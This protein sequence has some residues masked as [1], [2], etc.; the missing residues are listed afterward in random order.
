MKAICVTED[1][2][3]EVRDI[4]APT[5]PPEGHVLIDVEA[6]AINHG[7]KTF[8]TS[9]TAAAGLSTSNHDVWGASASGKV[10]AVG[11]DVPEKFA[12]SNV[13]IYR[14]L[15]ASPQIVGL[16]SERAMVPYT[17]CLMLPDNVPVRAY[18]GSLVNVITAYAF[19]EEVAAEG[20]KGVIVTAGNSATGL[21]IA[22]LVQRRDV[23]AIFL[24]RSEVSRTELL[25]SGVRNVLATN[26]E[27][28]GSDFEKLAMQLD[29]TA[30]FDGVGGELITRL[31]PHL[32]ANSVVSFYGFLA[33]SARI[34]LPSS[35]FMAKN[36]V[37][38]RFS[39]FN[40]QT[41]KDKA[42]LSRA[43][44]YLEGIIEDPLF[45]TKL[46]N[47]FTFDQIDAAMAYEP[48]SGAKAIL[49]PSKEVE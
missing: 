20:H 11:R 32:P 37:F 1:R 46:G 24:V 49:V 42:K 22:G 38:R 27:C 47:T 2:R 41:V 40:S 10:R 33:G 4:P 23:P 19:L 29:A 17:S 21:A 26:S 8:L 44:E 7:D 36:L 9:P 14:S 39:N 12:G 30:I 31:A 16:W 15:T 13:A 48:P 34:S 45:R 5:Q 43:F 18:C 3:L 35:L 25:R 6:C 28:F